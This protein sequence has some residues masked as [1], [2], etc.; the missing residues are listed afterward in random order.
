[1]VY[2]LLTGLSHKRG[3]TRI[4]RNFAALARRMSNLSP[5]RQ[6]GRVAEP[7]A[8]LIDKVDTAKQRYRVR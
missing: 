6:S 7:I 1:M 2:T 5:P 8:S 3:M 4:D